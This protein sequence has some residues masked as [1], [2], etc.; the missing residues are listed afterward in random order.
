MI[1]ATT[2]ESMGW[3][4]STSQDKLVWR[5]GCEEQVFPRTSRKRLPRNWKIEENLLMSRSSKTSKNFM[6]CPRLR[7]NCW[8]RREG[9]LRETAALERPTFPVN[10]LLFRVPEPCF[11]AI[12]DCRTIHGILWVLQETYWND[13]L[14]KTDKTLL[15]STFLA[16]SSQ[17]KMGPDTEGTTEKLESEMR[18]ELQHSSIFIPRWSG[19]GLLN[20]TGVFF[21]QWCDWLSE[22]FRFRSCIWKKNPESVEFQCWK[23]NFKNEV[24]SHISQ[25][26]GSKKLRQWN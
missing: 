1:T 14:L 16:S 2:D 3:S 15:S 12:L 24:C 21:S 23:V 19:G 25:C 26:N 9:I 4:G 18:R 20:C 6:N 22:I 5:K 11:A 17:R 13:Y 8:S 7:V 10:T